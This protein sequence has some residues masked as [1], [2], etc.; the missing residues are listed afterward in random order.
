MFAQEPVVAEEHVPD[1][2]H[3]LH[4]LMVVMNA[5]LTMTLSMKVVKTSHVQ[6]NILL[7]V[8]IICFG[9]LYIYRYPYILISDRYL[10][11]SIVQL[12][13]SGMIGHLGPALRHAEVVLGLLFV[14]RRMQLY[15]EVKNVP[16]LPRSL[17][18]AA[19]FKSAQVS[20]TGTDSHLNFLFI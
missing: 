13:V 10:N 20:S 2:D 6:V 4:Q 1:T 11:S 9:Y 12:I 17:T 5:P 15:M 19:T 8:K 14:Q 18:H 16:E 7:T 3:V